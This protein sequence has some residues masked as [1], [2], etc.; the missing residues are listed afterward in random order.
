MKKLIILTAA[1]FAILFSSIAAQS[2]NTKILSL[3]DIFSKGEYY[4]GRFGPTKWMENGNAY[5]MLENSKLYPGAYD[6]V[7]YNTLTGESETAIS[8]SQMIPHNSSSPLDIDDYEWSADK[9]KLMLFT[10]TKKVW[11]K[12]TRGDYYVLFL[13]SGELKQI[14]KDRPSSSLMFAKFSP[15][16]NRAAYVSKNNIYVEDLSTGKVLQLTH[17]GS[18]TI[19]NGTFDWVYEEELK[20]RDG[21]SWSPD[22][23]KIAYWQLD[24][25]GIGEFLLINNTD[26]LYSFTIPVQYPKVGT[27]NSAARV[28]VVNSAGGETKW[29]QVPGDPRNNYIARMQWAENNNE[30]VIQHLN[31]LQN[32]NEIMLCEVNS[33]N[34]STVLT[35]TDK[36]WVDVKNDFKWF[37]NGKH[38]SWVSERD[39]WRHLYLVSRDGKEIKLLTPGNYDVISVEN[40]NDNDGW[41]YFIASPEDNSTRYLYR[42]PFD[43]SGTLERITPLDAK[44]THEYDISPSNKYAFHKYSNFNTPVITDLVELPS[45]KVIRTLHKNEELINNIHNVAIKNVEFFRITP[46]NGITYDAWMMKPY[47]FDPAKKYPVLFFVYSE[48]GGQTVLD[49]WRTSRYMWHAYLTQLGYIVMS[50]DSRGTPAPRGRD[51]R[52]SVYKKIGITA[53]VDQAEAAKAIMKKYSFVDKDRIGIWGWSGG[54]TMTLNMMFRYPDIYKTGM[55]VAPVTNQRFYDS[56][57]QERYMSLPSENEDG[58]RNGSPINYAKYLKGNL[59]LVHGTGDDN[60]HYQ[61]TEVLINELIKYN[62]QFSM[63]AYPNRTHSIYQGKGTTIHLYTLLTN[64][65]LKNL[66]AGA[67]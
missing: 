23:S 67:K 49:K 50:V 63:M 13:E 58:Y 2:N 55:C 61:N 12:K 38:F 28:G 15:D 26:S 46:E 10:N 25:A 37:K 9:T 40:I 41:I 52:K 5:T 47:N 43:G 36:A 66:E 48:P 22:G 4:D 27:T 59:L 34:V 6:I 65:L 17:D 32:K 3:E 7:K 35:E 30:I 21:F 19:I 33:G 42:V 14:G 64:Y 16:G 62:K 57:Y 20:V 31:R 44:G 39:G 1:L 11:R 53:S 24:A 45:H 54:G 51:W 29:M 56:I 60:V 8:A 18:K